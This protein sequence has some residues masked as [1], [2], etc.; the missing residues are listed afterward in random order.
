MREELGSTN[1]PILLE[2]KVFFTSSLL[3]TKGQYKGGE[4]RQISPD[5]HKVQA[6]F[7][8][9]IPKTS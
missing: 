6:A 4:M 5:K 3:R 9:T 1:L 8:S 7:P 2:P